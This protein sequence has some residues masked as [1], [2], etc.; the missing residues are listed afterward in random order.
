M[1]TPACMDKTLLSLFHIRTLIVKTQNKHALQ[2]HK[3]TVRKT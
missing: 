1:L 2:Y 3:L